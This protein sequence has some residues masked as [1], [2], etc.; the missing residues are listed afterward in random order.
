MISYIKKYELGKPKQHP[1]GMTS[2]F[3]DGDNSTLFD[4]PA[5][6]ISPNG[7]IDD[8]PVAD[9]SKVILAD[10]DHFCGNCG[11]SK[12][13]WKSFMRGENPVF[14]DAYDNAFVLNST[15]T[16]IVPPDPLNYNLWVSLRRNLGYT[17]TYANRINLAAM[18]PRNDLASTG[19]CL[20]NPVSHEAEYLVYSPYSGKVT[21]DL[22]KTLGEVSVEWFNP[23]SG[24]VTSGITT[25]GGGNRSFIPPFDGDAILYIRSKLS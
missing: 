21:V 7:G 22:S 8:R 23:N 12:W 15:L 20:A 14:M 19:Y 2:E 18:T 13:V 3:P 17:L 24:L 16:N 5:D 9:G 4:S 25:T 11:D 10:T 6:W 1:V